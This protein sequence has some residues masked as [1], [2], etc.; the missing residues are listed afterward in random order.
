MRY[1]SYCG[2]EFTKKTSYK[3]H[4]IVCEILQDISKRDKKINAEETTNIPT[5]LE[6]YKIILEL[7]SKQEK[8]ENQIKKLQTNQK[9]MDV[10]DWLNKNITPEKSYYEWIEQI[11]IDN[12]VIDFLFEKSL[13]DTLS[14]V[15]NKHL[16]SSI[17]LNPLFGFKQKTNMLYKYNNHEIKWTKLNQEDFIFL[18]KNIEKILFNSMCLWQKENIV[19]LQNDNYLEI[20][21]NNAM[22]KLTSACYDSESS[23]LSKVRTNLYNKIKYELS[24]CEMIFE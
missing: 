5:N 11:N 12:Y 17:S 4:I 2:K 21:F 3:K 23:L 10:I 24:L 18:L 20:K 14:F 15:I 6:L 19:L 22:I 16:Y 13:A 7:S 9:K 8:L 1:C